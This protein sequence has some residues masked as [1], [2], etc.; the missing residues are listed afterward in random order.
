LV[1]KVFRLGQDSE[2]EPRTDLKATTISE[3]GAIKLRLFLIMKSKSLVIVFLF[4]R[5][6]AMSIVTPQTIVD[7]NILIVSNNFTRLN[8]TNCKCKICRKSFAS[9]KSELRPFFLEEAND[10]PHTLHLHFF[11][12]KLFETINVFRST[13]VCGVKLGIVA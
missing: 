8:L 2:I 3:I 6:A 11:L 10:F 1:S 9:S 4:Y 5:Y 12:V 7:R 13:T